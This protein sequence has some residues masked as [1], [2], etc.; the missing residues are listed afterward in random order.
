MIF[1]IPSLLLSLFWLSCG[2]LSFL[3]SNI[4]SHFSGACMQ[5]VK[6]VIIS[7]IT[8]A[9][10]LL[11][12]LPQCL[13]LPLIVR[14]LDFL[15]WVLGIGPVGANNSGAECYATQKGR[16]KSAA[17]FPKLAEVKHLLAPSQFSWENAI[18]KSARREQTHP[19][20]N[21]TNTVFMGSRSNFMKVDDGWTYI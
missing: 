18:K 14:R 2:K 16:H 21:R 17:A 6:C 15:C 7:L 9:L 5:L 11:L 4:S 3:L 12:Y 1:C 20:E 13:S 19:T 10:H 8:A